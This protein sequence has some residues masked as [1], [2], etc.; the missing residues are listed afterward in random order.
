MNIDFSK[1]VYAQNLLSKKVKLV[2]LIDE[3]KV[4]GGFDASYKKDL[5]VGCYFA[6]ECC[7]DIRIS[8]E[9]SILRGV[10]E[11]VPGLFF[12]RESFVFFRTV[13]EKPDLMFINAHGIM[14][15]RGYGFASHVGT[16]LKVPSIGVATKLLRGFTEENGKVFFKG[17]QVGW[18]VNFNNKKYYVSPGNYISLKDSLDLFLKNASVNGLPWPLYYA[19][20]CSK[21]LIKRLKF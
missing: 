18:A 5:A 1:A 4:V 7:T 3:P 11:Y 8:F 15:P 13:K 17:K 12:L 20:K 14:H 2:D 10:P 16:A 21:D 6:T 19:D 9:F